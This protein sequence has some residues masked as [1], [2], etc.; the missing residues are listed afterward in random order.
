MGTV[1]TEWTKQPWLKKIKKVYYLRIQLMGG[2]MVTLPLIRYLFIRFR[3]FL[4]RCIPLYTE[5]WIEKT[6]QNK[7]ITRKGGEKGSDAKMIGDWRVDSRVTHRRNASEGTRKGGRRVGRTGRGRRV[8]WGSNIASTMEKSRSK[9]CRE[10]ERERR[11]TKRVR[12]IDSR[13]QGWLLFPQEPHKLF[14]EYSFG[15]V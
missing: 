13:V 7:T 12:A 3:D 11:G 2:S 14:W 10:R 9:P 1:S 4:D 6:K 8:G 5:H 15:K